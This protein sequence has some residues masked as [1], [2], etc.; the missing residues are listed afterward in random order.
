MPGR[1][2]EFDRRGFLRLTG[3]AGAVGAIGGAGPL[4][5]ACSSGASGPSPKSKKGIQIGEHVPG[6]QPVSGGR[7]GGTVKVAWVDPPDSFDPAVGANLT[8]WDCVTELVYFGALMA[9]DGQFGGPVP[10][11]AAVPPAISQ[12]GK[13]LTFRIRPGVKYHNGQTI[14]AADFKYAWER[15]LDPKTQ[16]WGASY[17][18]SVAGAGDIT[19][20]KTKQ[21]A[22]VEVKGDS[23]LVVHLTAPDFTVLNALTLPITAPVPSGEVARLGKAWGQRPVGYGP[24]KITS[25][26]SAAQTARFER[27]PDYFYAGLPYLDAVE[28]HWGVDPQIELLQ[29]E[30]GDIDIIGDGIPASSAAQ[31]LASPTL[32]SLARETSSPGN[33]YFTMYPTGVPAFGSKLV[34]QAM[35]WAINKEALGKI[36]YGTSTP[37]GA[38]FP[39]HLADFTPT[40][41]PYGYD[42]AMAKR[43]LAQAGYKHGFS[44]TL[45]V[46]SDPPFPSIAQVVQQQLRAVGVHVAINQVGAN[47]LYSLEYAEQK[48][49]KKLQMSTD[50]WYMVQPTPADEVDAIY[51]TKASS[52]FNGYSNPEVDRLAKQA[53]SDFNPISRNK[54]YA[55][56]QQLI[57][58]DAPFI[59][60]ASTDFLAGVSKRVQNYRYRAET[61]S[62]YDRMW[63]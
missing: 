24:F 39:S 50:L 43:L 63:V 31:V 19:S 56:I 36:T 52:N 18:A 26:D 60:I 47:A 44:F 58:E 57:G 21:L 2:W 7:R 33:L 17:L 23:T 3:A 49:S 29:L 54:I 53:A 32:K 25:Y 38:P 14:V 48:G 20:G 46:A 45:T 28:Y 10:N 9:Y 22:G 30:H 15:T 1:G 16:S 41:K 12:D 5:A 34:R 61:Y 55:K 13:T 4:L 11:L 62:Y 6:P 40:F 59:F 35:N 37:W 51:V 42:P 27:N 8:G